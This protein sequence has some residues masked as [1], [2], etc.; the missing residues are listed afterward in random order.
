VRWTDSIRAMRKAG[1]STFIELGSGNVLTG[2]LKR[3]DAEAEGVGLG[4][5]DDFEKLGS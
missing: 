4:E 5:P 2:L 3:I 1:V